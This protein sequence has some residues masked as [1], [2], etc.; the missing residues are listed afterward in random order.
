MTKQAITIKRTKKDLT[1]TINQQTTV[2]YI[3]DI[4]NKLKSTKFDREN[5]IFK[6]PKDTEPDLAFI[7]ML[8]SLKKS[9]LEENQKI[10]LKAPL[11]ATKK[12]VILETINEIQIATT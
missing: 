9:K 11:D 6:L 10:T 7:Q 12:S 2:Q 4:F 3:R 5:I 1:V 8:I